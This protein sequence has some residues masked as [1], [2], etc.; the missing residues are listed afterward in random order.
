MINL[1]IAGLGKMGKLHYKTSIKNKK[2]NLV[3]VADVKKN[4]LKIVEKSTVKKYSDYKDMIDS[5]KLDAIII[6]L[7]NF[8]KK[9]SI[10]YSSENDLAIFIDKPLSRNLSEAKDIIK[11]IEKS[12]TQ[13][14]V[15]VNYRFFKC[16]KK[17]R[18]VIEQGNVGEVVLATS[19]LIMDGPFSHPLIPAPVA[20]W[21]FDKD[22]SGGGVVL[23]L[24]YHLIDLL[25][26]IF[27][28]LDV[29]YSKL[30]HRYNLPIEDAATIIL[31]T[32]CG[33]R[34]TVNVGWFSKMLFPNF[35]FRMNFHGTVGYTSTDKFTPKNM[36]TNAILE[37]MKNFLRRISARNIEYLS[38]TYYYTSFYEILDNFFE[39]ILLDQENPINLGQQLSVMK[40]LDTVY[41]L[42]EGSKCQK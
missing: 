25:T 15:G 11:N 30:M 41:N 3:A 5:E 4:N 7:P 10:C 18:D 13:L 38:Y 23:D 26:W 16:I 12:N 39:S 42:A 37:G 6:S 32:Q 31:G 35:N 27:G 36:Y 22:L 19:E 34:C 24:G 29:E 9:E 17:V 33:A 1:G 2:I 28:D 40:T 8:L 21:W 20:E 14:T